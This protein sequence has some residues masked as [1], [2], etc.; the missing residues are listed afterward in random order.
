R[1]IVPGPSIDTV[2]LPPLLSATMATPSPL[3][4]M[5]VPGAADR[6]L[7]PLPSRTRSS[8]RAR[9][10]NAVRPRQ[11]TA[12]TTTTARVMARS[13]FRRFEESPLLTNEAA[14]Q[15]NPPPSRPGVAPPPNARPHF[16]ARLQTMRTT[17]GPPL[18][19]L[20][21]SPLAPCERQNVRVS[22][23]IL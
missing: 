23:S 2:Y 12:A 10:P 14:L 17:P 7:R 15:T 5:W 3:F 13:A 11:A 16:S 9:P 1:Y 20:G 18:K 22:P 19:S 6:S 4:L 21:R 8:A